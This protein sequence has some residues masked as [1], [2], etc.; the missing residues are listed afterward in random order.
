L[1][2]WGVEL[3]L[4]GI[5]G[6]GAV[7]M[8]VFAIRRDSTPT[9]FLTGA[10]LCANGWLMNVKGI[11]V[12][13]LLLGLAALFAWIGVLRLIRRPGVGVQGEG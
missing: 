5:Y 4:V 6:V 12:A 1:A 10:A 3:L 13:P 11:R 8:L 7:C 2:K 9:L